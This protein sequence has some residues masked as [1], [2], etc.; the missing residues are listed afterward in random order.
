MNPYDD[1]QIELR[2][3]EVQEILGT[4]PGWLIRWGTTAAFLTFLVLIAVGWMVRYPDVIKAKIVLTTGNPPV[5]LVARTDGNI[6]RLLVQD[7]EMVGRGTEL[8]VL[9][10]TARYEDIVQLDI[11]V[12][13]WQNISV[14]SLA[15]IFP[16]GGL[17]LGD[18]QNDYSAFVQNLESYRFSRGDRRSSVG[19]NIS[20]INQQI[21]RLQQSIRFDERSRQRAEQ[22]IAGARDLFDRQEE[23][24]R[25]GLISKIA[26][27]QE[28]LKVA[29]AESAA[30]K[31]EE[32]IIRKQNEIISLRKSINETA[33]SE[34]A[35]DA[36]LS[37]RLRES[38]NALRNSIDR[39]KQKYL[40]V[41]PVDGRVSMN[42]SYFSAQQFVKQ[43]EQV[44]TIVPPTGA[45]KII[46]RLSLPA[47][48]SGKVTAGRRVV[49]KLD[50]YPFQEFGSLEGKVEAKALIPK[51]EAYNIIVELP[52]ELKTNY[53][54]II[55]FEQQ[56]QGRAE[57]ITED[58]RF[59]ERILEHAFSI[60]Q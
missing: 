44:L 33:F 52:A 40:L 24:F 54:K 39:W 53:G 56:M 50:G 26:L 6:A 27:E 48:G 25:Q 59:L 45:G 19:S 16:P 11:N 17:E 37:V 31:I 12:A 2:S 55:P 47:A 43:G 15:R 36:S 46:G 60:G 7:N 51:D 5:E 14:D 20:A 41:A 3:D 13:R 1:H 28:R 49:V 57:I 34:R 22:Q 23:L 35:D 4:P 38:L 32:G 58:K 18:V 21:D 10:S 42:T 30:D 29:E 8:V 9:Q